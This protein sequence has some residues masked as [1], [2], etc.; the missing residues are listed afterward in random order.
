[1]WAFLTSYFEGARLLNTPD[2]AAVD[3]PRLCLG[4]PQKT[5]TQKKEQR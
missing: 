1:M 5:L 2:I 4:E 3:V